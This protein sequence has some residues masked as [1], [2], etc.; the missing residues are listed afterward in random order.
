[1]TSRPPGH[2]HL[3]HGLHEL[4]PARTPS[5]SE[6]QTNLQSEHK[7][8]MSDNQQ[9]TASALYDSTA[10]AVRE[11]VAKVTGNPHDQAA[12]DEK[13]RTCRSFER[14]SDL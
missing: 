12:A 10:S 9:S 2:E 8:N 3:N 6:S 14:V 11:G 4:C 5:S 7:Q 1:M 13:K